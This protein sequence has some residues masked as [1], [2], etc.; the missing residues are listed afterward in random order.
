VGGI[1]GPIFV[2]IVKDVTGS[3]RGAL[4]VIAIMLL[5]SMLLPVFTHRPSDVPGERPKRKPVFRETPVTP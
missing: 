3:F 1:V 4:P 5:A 2:S